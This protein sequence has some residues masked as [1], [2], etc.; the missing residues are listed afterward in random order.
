[1]SLF[2]AGELVQTAV[3]IERIGAAFY[4]ALARGAG[5]TQARLEFSALADAEKDHER[6]FTSMLER[7]ETAFEPAESYPDEYASYMTALSQTAVFPD[8][9]AAVRLAKTAATRADALDLAIRAE[10]DS[11]LFYTG[12]RR[13]TRE[14]QQ[15][16]VDAII[17][18]EQAHLQRLQEMKA[19]AR[20]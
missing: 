7:V 3:N 14:G 16:A 6:T 1:M 2:Q 5:D 19:T 20:S 17:A 8:E 18:E 15:A 4:A 9:R 13:V 11:I 12:M 10:K